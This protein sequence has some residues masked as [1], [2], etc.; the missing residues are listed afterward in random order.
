VL[1]VATAKEVTV[2]C[3]LS[4]NAGPDG[5]ARIVRNAFGIRAARKALV[6]CLG[7]A[8]A[9][10][11]GADCSAIK[12]QK[13]IANISSRLAANVAAKPFVTQPS[14]LNFH[15]LSFLP[16]Q[17]L[18]TAPTTGHATTAAR[19][20]TPDRA[21]TPANVPKVSPVSTAK[22]A[23]ISVRSNLVKMAPFVG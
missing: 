10:R 16:I 8:I 15:I 23:K 12:V 3:H 14:E 4:V 21:A 18:I 20:P 7:N 6:R 22:S 2:T 13:I 19:A 1:L 5:R 17:I 11:A 9:M